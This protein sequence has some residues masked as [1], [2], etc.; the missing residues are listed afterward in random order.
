[1]CLYNNFNTFSGGLPIIPFLPLITIGLSNNF[2]CLAIFSI[3]TSSVAFIG[4]FNCLY[5]FSFVL[6]MSMADIFKF[7]HI[8]FNSLTFGGFLRYSIIFGS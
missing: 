2:G 6:V 5:S 3:N 7:S 1:M 4:I 8:S